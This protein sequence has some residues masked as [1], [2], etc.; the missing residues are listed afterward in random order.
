MI[1]VKHLMM[2]SISALAM[3]CAPK[4]PV[5]NSARL[6]KSRTGNPYGMRGF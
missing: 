1:T 5:F 3:A 2:I 6:Q 4:E